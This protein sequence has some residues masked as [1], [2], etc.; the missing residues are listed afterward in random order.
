MKTIMEKNA[1]EIMML[2][3]RIKRYQ[4]MGNGVMCQSLNG[5]L[6]KLLAHKQN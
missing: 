1:N 5:K 3:Y 4:A 6:Q 2:M